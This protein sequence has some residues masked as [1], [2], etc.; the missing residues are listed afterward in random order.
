MPK[1]AR[2]EV[3]PLEPGEY[4]RPMR[5]ANAFNWAVGSRNWTSPGALEMALRAHCLSSC[6]IPSYCQ[7]RPTL[8]VKFGFHRKLSF[9]NAEVLMAL[10]EYGATPTLRSASWSGV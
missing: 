6:G 8:T 7:R 10:P 4:A 5:G 9:T 1:P 3:L 2:M